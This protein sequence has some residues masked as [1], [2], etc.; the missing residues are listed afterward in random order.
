MTT[1]TLRLLTVLAL[2]CLGVPAAAQSTIPNQKLTTGS[3]SGSVTLKGK[4]VP[5]IGVALRSVGSDQPRPAL[6]ATTDPEGNYRISRVPAGQYQVAPI[7]PT[8]V[9]TEMMVAGHQGKL[10]ILTEGES[11]DGIDFTLVKGGVITGKVLDADGRPV[12]EEPLSLTA[13]DSDNPVMQVQQFNFRTDDR[14]VYR[15]FGMPAGRYRVAVGQSSRMAALGTGQPRRP[16]R[17]TFHPDA[18]DASQATIVEVLEGGES[19][20]ID[21][22]VGRILEPAEREK[23]EDVRFFASLVSADGSFALNNL[24]PGRYLASARPAGETSCRSC[25]FRIRR[26]AAP[27]CARKLKPPKLKSI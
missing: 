10:V 22:T 20:G 18:A 19:A 16:Y 4:C 13:A 9:I 25:A 27:N 24:P 11:V 6:I 12:V 7:A 8:F 23:A 26:K 3:V 17:L 14:G 15:I 1:L 5:G 2:A 21:I